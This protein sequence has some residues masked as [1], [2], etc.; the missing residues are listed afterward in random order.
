MG[1]LI[2]VFGRCLDGVFVFGI[3]NGIRKLSA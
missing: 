1:C 3:I 2:G